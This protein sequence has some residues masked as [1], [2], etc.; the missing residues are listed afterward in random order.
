MARC[1]VTGA[2]GFV[3]P[4]LTRELQRH[5]HQVVA[6][7]HRRALAPHSVEC[8]AHSFDLRDVESVQDLLETSRPERIFHLAAMTFVPDVERRRPEAYAI[9]VGG[10]L[11]LLETAERT[12]PQARVLLASSA[13]VYAPSESAVTE[14]HPTRPAS[15][16][17]FTKLAAEA[18]AEHFRLRGSHVWVARAFNHI[19]PR[20]GAEFAVP[21]F[22]RQIVEIE[23]GQ[24]EPT[25]E[26]GNLESLRDFT[27]VR[28]VARAYAALL[29]SAP[30]QGVYNVASGNAV[31][32]GAVLEE[33]R[34]RSEREIEVTLDAERLRE[35]ERSILV[36]DSSKLRSRTGWAP[37][38]PLQ[39]SLD[40][41]LASMRKPG[42]RSFQCAFC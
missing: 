28:D 42:G 41:V 5:G 23:R 29:E 22:A 38:V 18:L 13:H 30:A 14:S 2:A 20:Q 8:Q 7:L 35:G 16:Y 19:G 21:S 32:M 1:L 6:A 27:D 24:R 36:G 11:N 34:S 33:L 31:S 9:N 40:S 37:E 17:G 4:Y 10:T 25:L 39:Q 3:G 26:V 15:Y 12:A